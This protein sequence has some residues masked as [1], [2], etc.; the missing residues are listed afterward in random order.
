MMR[1]LLPRCALRAPACR[2]QRL[3]LGVCQPARAYSISPE[4]ASDSK[5]Q[6]IDPTQLVIERTRD[7]KPLKKSEDL[8]FGQNFTGK[9]GLQRRGGGGAEGRGARGEGRRARDA[10]LLCFYSAG[11][12]VR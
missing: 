6:D 10:P 4:T 8:V 7:P 1:R 3:S 12:D 11:G 2:A 5:L 9:S